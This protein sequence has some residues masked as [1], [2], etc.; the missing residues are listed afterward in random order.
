M[1][2]L[3]TFVFFPCG[4]TAADVPFGLVY[5]KDLLYPQVKAAVYLFETLREIFMYGGLAD[6][7]MF[8]CCP[9]CGSVIY[10]VLSKFA[11]TPLNVGFQ[12]HHSKT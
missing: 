11:G 3:Y 9:D 5:L 7:K 4:D 6:S 1:L 12:M 2:A 10:Y 8:G